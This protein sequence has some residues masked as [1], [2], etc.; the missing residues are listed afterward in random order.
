MHWCKTKLF[1]PHRFLLHALADEAALVRSCGSSG[2]AGSVADAVIFALTLVCVHYAM[3]KPIA[4]SLQARKLKESF[5]R[6]AI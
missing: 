2:P 3:R 1:H 5:G 4:A 6:F